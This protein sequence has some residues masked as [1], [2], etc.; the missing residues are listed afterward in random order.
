MRSDDVLACPVRPCGPACLD[1]GCELLG[2]RVQVL[3]RGDGPLQG[4]LLLARGAP[5]P[6]GVVRASRSDE[7]PVVIPRH[8]VHAARVPPQG[9]LLLH[10]RG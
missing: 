8:R 6:N 3:P 9:A 7:S 2:L 10:R 1:L 5:Q 4:A